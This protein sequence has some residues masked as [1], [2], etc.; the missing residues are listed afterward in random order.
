MKILRKLF[1]QKYHWFQVQYSYK[2]G[3]RVI[4]DWYSQV[5]FEN[6]R[7]VINDRIVKEGKCIFLSN[8]G[9]K[10]LLCNG[11]LEVRVVAYLGKFKPLKS[12]SK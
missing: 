2:K 1:P 7:D 8:K 4:F 11:H 5:G 12:K 10:E 3:S 6:R 9:A